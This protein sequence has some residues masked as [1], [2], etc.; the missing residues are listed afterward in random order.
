[1][2]YPVIDQS[3]EALAVHHLCQLTR[4]PRSS[5]YRHRKRPA[6]SG[7][8][9]PVCP[10]VHRICEEYP[11][12]G[13]RRVMH[14]LRR[15]G[16]RANHKRILALMRQQKLLCRPRRR[17]LRTTDS[18]H[19][20]P[21]YANLVPR[22]TLTG[23]NQLWVA[24]LTY[25]RLT[26]GFAYLA[27]LLDAWSRRAI[28]W[29]ISPHIDTQLSLQALRMALATRQVGPGLVHHSDQ[30]VQYASADYVDLLQ[31]RHITI[32]MSRTGNPYDNALAESFIKTLKTEEVYLNEYRDL[33]DAK[34]NIEQFIDQLYN[35]KRL[36]SSIGYRTPVE[37]EAQIENQTLNPS[38][39]TV[40][41]TVSV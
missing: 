11:R 39:L 34:N 18:R 13:Y 23:P 30:G 5:Y 32:S 6:V 36:H 20:L 16:Y 3:S 25:I 10:E 15:R 38:T 21:V 9:D 22:M 41:K 24:D 12:Y 29:A 14:E 7:A 2:I 1:M 33:L 17:F 28:G 19:G 4:I 31:S 35:Q 37:Y 40:A 27:V 8:L 26:H